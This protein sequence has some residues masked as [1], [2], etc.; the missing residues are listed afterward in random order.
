[1]SKIHPVLTTLFLAFILCFSS[2]AQTPAQIKQGPAGVFVFTGKSIPCGKQISE[3]VLER[4]A[5]SGEWTLLTRLKTPAT[6][7]LFE[8]RVNQSKTSF[9]SQPIPPSGKLREIY[10]KAVALGHTDSLRNQRLLNPIRMALGLIYYDTSAAKNITYRYRVSAVKAGNAGTEAFLS[11]TVS[12]PYQARFD[13]IKVSSTSYNRTSVEVTWFSTGSNPAP[14]FMV[15]K[16]I[17]GAPATAHGKT[18]RYSVND[19]TYYVYNDTVSGRDT[20]KELQFFVAPYDFYGNAGASSQNAIILQDNFYRGSFIR[21][22]IAFSYERSGIE[23]CWHFSD[24]FTV[25]TIEIYRS[26]QT[27]TGFTKIGEALASDTVYLDQKIW[28]ERTYYYYVQAIAKAGKR[29]MKSAVLSAAVPGIGISRKLNAPVLKQVAVVRNKVRLLIVVNDTAATELRVYRG[30][31]GS[32]TALQGTIKPGAPV[33]TF[34]DETLAPGAMKDVVYAVR[35]EK[36]EVGVSGLSE[37]KPVAMVVKS[38]EA[39]YFYAIPAEGATYLYW[40][41]V[42]GRNSSCASYTLARQF[43]VPGSKTPLKIL[44][45]NLGT[46]SFVDTEVEPGNQVTYVLKLKNAKGEYAEK[47]YRVSVPETGK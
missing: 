31:S 3:Y 42:A 1:M 7:E 16:F 17:Y 45:E 38:D 4:S 25:K 20:G 21:N 19:T 6:F 37:E 39:G 34:T 26:A 41:D 22:H 36:A 12:L 32:L 13:S 27:G 44:A 14:L 40:D 23:F 9:P 33:I 18:S 2:G 46:S 43:G 11:D 15:Y 47:V 5:G 30:K 28:P 35:N 10:E 29:S 8:N 24:P